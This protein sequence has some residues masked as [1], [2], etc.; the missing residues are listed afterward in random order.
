MHKYFFQ[1]LLQTAL[2]KCNSYKFYETESGAC[3]IKILAI[4]FPLNSIEKNFKSELKFYEHLEEF[5]HYI[6]FLFQESNRQLQIVKN[7]IFKAVIQNTPFY[8]A[9]TAFLMVGFYDGPEN[10][11]ITEIFLKQ[12]LDMTENAA[13]FFL[14]SFS[15]KSSNLG[16]YIHFY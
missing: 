15:S 1:Y 3:L 16:N 4:W 12:T 10:H 13:N 14:N 8:G 2:N 9:L 11:L 5:Q 7:D 6:Q